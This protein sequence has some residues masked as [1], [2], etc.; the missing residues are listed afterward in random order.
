MPSCRRCSR[1]HI[2]WQILTR[3]DAHLSH[4][5]CC[6]W[7]HQPVQTARLL[8]LIS[9]SCWFILC[10][11]FFSPSYCTFNIIQKLFH[12]KI[13]DK[14]EHFNQSFHAEC[15]SNIECIVCT[16]CWHAI[17]SPCALLFSAHTP[18]NSFLGF[19]SAEAVTEGVRQEELQEDTKRK[20][21]IAV[22]YGKQEYMWQ[23]KRW[24]V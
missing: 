4:L 11:M 8:V 18:D 6:F 12:Y 22:V 19:V 17:Q 15:S 2:H 13:L 3:A 5:P 1:T 20:D 14:I 10:G 7:G 24:N 9:F 23:V 16:Q 21:R